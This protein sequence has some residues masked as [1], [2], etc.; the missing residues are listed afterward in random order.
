MSWNTSSSQLVIGTQ[1]GQVEVISP[2]AK[3]IDFSRKISA[4][5]IHALAWHPDGTRI[6]KSSLDGQIRLI[7]ASTGQTLLTFSMPEMD[8]GLSR[9]ERR[10]TKVGRVLPEWSHPHLGC[11]AR[12]RNRPGRLASRRIG[13]GVLRSRSH[14]RRRRVLLCLREALQ[15]APDTLD[16]WNL[17]GSIYAILGE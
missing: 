4:E 14:L 8:G 1:D 6:V 15:H 13:L 11:G 17:R 3:R 7:E 16:F 2:R 10:W 9:M 5:P 12:L